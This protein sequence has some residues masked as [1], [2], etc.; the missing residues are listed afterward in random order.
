MKSKLRNV[1][2]GMKSKPRSVKGGM[3]DRIRFGWFWAQVALAGA[4]ALLCEQGW[5]NLMDHTDQEDWSCVP[6]VV[7]TTTLTWLRC[8]VRDT[9]C[10]D[11]R[12][13]DCGEMTA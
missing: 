5:T 13:D 6:D 1:K 2:G 8:A 9:P 11:C 10:D 4:L 7:D 3:K 12:D